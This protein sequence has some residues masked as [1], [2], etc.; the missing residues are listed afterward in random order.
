MPLNQ[1]SILTSAQGRQ[2]A[3][4]RW[5]AAASLPVVSSSPIAATTDIANPPNA[6]FVRAAAMAGI[7]GL[8]AFIFCELIRRQFLR[9]AGAKSNPS[10]QDAASVLGQPPQAAVSNRGQGWAV[11]IAL[12]IAIWVF[13]SQI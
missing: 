6:S 7:A 11:L 13:V 12:A 9:S 8:A 5:Q 3:Q 1:T 2:L 10:L 4:R